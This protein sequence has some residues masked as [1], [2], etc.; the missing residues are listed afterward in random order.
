MTMPRRSAIKKTMKRIFAARLFGFALVGAL[1][2]GLALQARTHD[3]Y[4]ASSMAPAEIKDA[5]AKAAHDHK[6]VILD[7]GGNW[8][9]DCHALDTYFHKAPNAGLLKSNFVLVDVNVGRMD[10]NLDIAKKYG[11]P[12]NKGVP[13]LAVLDSNGNVLFSQKN[14]EFE[15]MRTMDPGSVTTFLNHWK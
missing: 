1:G 12:L 3:I 2:T 9:G 14:G 8:C 13:A 10:Q 7:F 11:V 5:L 4:P 6:K 15:A